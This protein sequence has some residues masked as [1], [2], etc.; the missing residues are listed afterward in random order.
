LHLVVLRPSVA[1]LEARDHA[2]RTTTGK[3]AYRRDFTPAVNDTHVAETPA[4]LG[5]WLDTSAL[6][7]AETVDAVVAR[8]DEARIG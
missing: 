4:H 3:V 6:T 7:P 1:A 2:R 5:L 8:R